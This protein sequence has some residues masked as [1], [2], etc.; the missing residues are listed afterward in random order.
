MY[1]AMEM[2]S[3]KRFRPCDLISHSSS[4]VHVIQYSLLTLHSQIRGAKNCVIISVV[5]GTRC[6]LS[7]ASYKEVFQKAIKKIIL[8]AKV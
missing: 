5:S 1:N 7:L 2:L 6:T 3:D 4:S 8:S